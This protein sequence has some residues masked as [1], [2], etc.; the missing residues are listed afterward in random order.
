MNVTEILFVLERLLISD[1][2]TRLDLPLPPLQR[3]WHISMGF[4]V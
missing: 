3:A 4:I 1:V 2:D